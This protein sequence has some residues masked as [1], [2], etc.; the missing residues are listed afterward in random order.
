MR[1][2]DDDKRKE[3]KEKGSWERRK[4]WHGD[5]W[6]RRFAV[7]NGLMPQRLD[8]GTSLCEGGKVGWREVKKKRT[9]VPLIG[10]VSK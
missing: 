6:C 2:N 8:S 4:K 9:I 3:K 1:N 7:N 10:V 5:G